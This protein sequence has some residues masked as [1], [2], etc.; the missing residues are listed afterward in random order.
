MPDASEYTIRDLFESFVF[1]R[2]QGSTP[3]YALRELRHF[4]PRVSPEERFEL[5]HLIRQWEK[6]EGVSYP[7]DPDNAIQPP[8]RPATRAVDSTL[9]SCPRCH[10]TQPPKA[11]YCYYC[12]TLLTPTGTPFLLYDVDSHQETNFGAQ[13][14]LVFTVRSF[15][16]KP[17]RIKVPS[18]YPLIV[19]RTTEDSVL[20]PDIDLGEFDG[21]GMGVSR[22]HATL[23]RKGN[24]V[25]LSDMGSLNYT[26]LNG[27]RVFPQEDRLLSDGSELRLARMVIR[28][29]FD[30][31]S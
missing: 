30:D 10:R 28:V 18:Q 16:H 17:I 8:P 4:R 31:R 21:H 15:E 20:I 2:R 12:G 13:S 23:Q 1:M 6:A 3:D 14:I 24:V 5:A 19:G 27:E 29:S 9:I 22:V 11:L 25:T 26:Y 7:P